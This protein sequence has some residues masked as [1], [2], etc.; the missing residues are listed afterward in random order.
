MHDWILEEEETEE[1][2]VELVMG[3]GFHQETLIGFQMRG[4]ILRVSATCDLFKQRQ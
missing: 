4:G 3:Y 2:W 1:R